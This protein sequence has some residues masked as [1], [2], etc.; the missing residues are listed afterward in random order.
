MRAGL[1][2]IRM[3]LGI[4]CILQVLS[5]YS[6]GFESSSLVVHCSDCCFSWPEKSKTVDFTFAGSAFSCVAQTGRMLL[7]RETTS[8]SRAVTVEVEP[9]LRT[10][11]WTRPV[12]S[13]GGKVEL[14]CDKNAQN[15]RSWFYLFVYLWFWFSFWRRSKRMPW[16]VSMCSLLIPV[17]N[18]RRKRCRVGLGGVHLLGVEVQFAIISVSGLRR[19]PWSNWRRRCSPCPLGTG[20]ETCCSGIGRPTTGKDAANCI[21]YARIEHRIFCAHWDR[22]ALSTKVLRYCACALHHTYVVCSGVNVLEYFTPCCSAVLS[23]M[24]QQVYSLPSLRRCDRLPISRNILKIRFP[25]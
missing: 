3:N 5:S 19:G 10:D 25:H 15:K 12:A 17:L 18:N 13:A 2:M 23:R 16:D 21:V 9:P 7:L 11:G 22:I 4:T 14:P 24:L 1:H 20:S 8:C 6:T